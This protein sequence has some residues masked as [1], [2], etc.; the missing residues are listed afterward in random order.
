M[1]FPN[2]DL[3]L[4]DLFLREFLAAQLNPQEIVSDLFEDRSN[5]EQMQIGT[6]LRSKS[7]VG[8]NRD[9]SEDGKRV[10]IL[11]HFPSAELPFP[12]I[13][14]SHGE[15]PST[16]R[17]LGDIVGESE[18]VYASDDETITGW[19]QPFGYYEQANFN[20]DVI[21]ATKEE[22]IWLSRFCQYFICQNIGEIGAKGIL[23]VNISLAD[24]R[25][26]KGAMQPMEAF[27]RGVRISAKLENTWTKTLL[28]GVYATGNNTAL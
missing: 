9:R 7:F 10:F 1:G 16:E 11:P 12:Q 26:E 19:K 13:G 23:E 4:K 22:T 18:P 3:I 17:F 25:L 6:Y 21:S 15:S 8:S 20:I 14:I 24:I 27:V 5:E 28:N 2:V